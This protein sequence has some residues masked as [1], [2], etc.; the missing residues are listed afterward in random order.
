MPDRSHSGLRGCVRVL[1]CHSKGTSGR[2][3]GLRDASSLYLSGSKSEL[4]KFEMQL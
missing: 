1:I 2:C 4:Y 3:R